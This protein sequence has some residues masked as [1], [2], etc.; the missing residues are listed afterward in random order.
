MNDQDRI[1]ALESK[2]RRQG[3]ALAGMGIGLALAVVM[4]MAQQAPKEMTLEAL[5]ITKDGTPRI[6]LGTNPEDGGVGMA[7][8]DLAGKVRV[9]I[10]TDAAGDG[11]M[12]VMDKNESPNIVMGSSKDGAGIMLIGASLTEIPTPAAP[13]APER[14]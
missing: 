12:A 14:K 2:I 5:T 3:F 7:F 10:G 1:V 6:M 11:G 8:M 9:A 4:G 13:A